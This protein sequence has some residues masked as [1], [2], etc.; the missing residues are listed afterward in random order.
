MPSLEKR[1]A[2]AFGFNPTQL[3]EELENLVSELEARNPAG[4]FRTEAQHYWREAC[5]TRYVTPQHFVKHAVTAFRERF[6][7]ELS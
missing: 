3:P 4:S 7:R 6:R 2:S 1:P 5:G